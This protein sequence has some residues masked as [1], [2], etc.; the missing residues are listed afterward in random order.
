MSKC[1]IESFYANTSSSIHYGGS[2]K[3][4]QTKYYAEGYWYKRDS[5]G[6][7]SLAEVLS[8]RA[9]RLTNANL[10]LVD[11]CP[12]YIVTKLNTFLGCKSASFLVDNSTE[13]T[14]A[15]L[16][17]NQL[18][19]HYRTADF[20]TGIRLLS[21]VTDCFKQLGESQR[22]C[23]QL[24]CLLQ[25][26]RLVMNVDRHLHNI[27]LI[28]NKN[29]FFNIVSFDNGD[30]LASDI[31]F[32]FDES[33]S[34]KECIAK[35]YARPFSSSFSSQCEMLMP[36]S[37]FSLKATQDTLKVSDLVGLIPTKIFT[38][39]LEIL[40]YNFYEYFGVNLKFL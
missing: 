24:S 18:G 14:L 6:Y 8:S 11:Y 34:C 30:S 15:R 17:E 40:S 21:T 27:V 26:D 16:L 20:P 12:V 29:G 36:Y 13:I 38:R 33:L 3:G 23:D 39:M 22:L 28:K 25:L 9:I 35:A 37:T 31:T 19:I 5:V 1:A 32:D 10:V 7:E 4:A 2:S